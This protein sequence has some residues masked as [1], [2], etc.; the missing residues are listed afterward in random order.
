MLIAAYDEDAQRAVAIHPMEYDNSCR[1]QLYAVDLLATFQ[2]EAALDLLNAAPV[3]SRTMLNSD[4]MKWVERNRANGISAYSNW[5][6]FEDLLCE[7]K[8]L[9]RTL[10]DNQ[11]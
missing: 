10:E 3:S 1:I 2:L 8:A 5:N 7:L 4:D 6:E 11:L 9:A